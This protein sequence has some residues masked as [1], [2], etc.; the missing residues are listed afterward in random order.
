MATLTP[1][2]PFHGHV[3]GLSASGFHR[4]HY[5]GWGDLAEGDPLVCVHGLTRNG[6][7]F[8]V[9]A[10]A[11]SE[12]FFAICPDIVGRGESDRL[13][14]PSGYGYPQYLSDMAVLLGHLGDQPVDWIGTSM[15][16]LIGMFLAAQPKS[17]IRRLVINDVG[18]LIP[19]AA[20]QRIADYITEKPFFSSMEEA[21]EYIRAIHAPFGDLT[22]DQWRH[23]TTHSVRPARGGFELRYDPAIADSFAQ[24]VDQ[25]VD[26]WPVWANVKCPV[27]ILRGATSDLLTGQTADEMAARHPQTTVLQIEGCGHAPALMERQQI[28]AIK[29]WLERTKPHEVRL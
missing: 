1:T 11:L 23:L 16:G 26:L 19:A 3:H 6:R 22:D 7:D 18:A 15:G 29:S 5:T 9:L 21:Q 20:L 27:L 14:D 4:I 28:E 2:E 10:H 12:R 25:D 13:A 24:S 17:P 8:D